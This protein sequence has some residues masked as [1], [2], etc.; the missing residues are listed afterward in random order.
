MTVGD[1][2]P[3]FEELSSFFLH[4]NGVEVEGSE[5]LKFESG[6]CLEIKQ[7]IDYQEILRFSMVVNK[8]RIL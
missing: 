1:Y 4:Y 8:C 2:T 7:F 5:C 3:K 6:L